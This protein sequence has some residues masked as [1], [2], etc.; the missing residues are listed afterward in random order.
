MKYLSKL[1]AIL[2]ALVMLLSA[3]ATAELDLSGILDTDAL[4]EELV[5]VED[6]AE[7]ENLPDEWWNI[8]LLG[9]DDRDEDGVA[10][11]RTDSMIILSVNLA[12]KEARLTS[13]MRDTWVPIEGH[14][15]N[16]LNSACVKGGPDLTMSTINECFGTNIKH[17]AMVNISGLADVIDRLGGVTLN[18]TEEERQALNKGLFDLS[19]MSGMEKLEKAGNGVLL[20]GNQAVAFA[21]I[22]K[23]DSDYQR[24][25]RQRDVLTAIAD[26]LKENNVVT[27]VGVVNGLLPYVET[28]LEL[29]D[30]MTLA[31]IGLQLD[32][33]TIKQLRL[34][35]DGTYESGTYNGVW[36]IKP[37]FEANQKKLYSFLAS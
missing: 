13:L 37:D 35:A 16:K 2:M 14:G 28:N 27:I 36:C 23:I 11:G 6:Y 18:V 8:L 1:L 19:S 5:S 26:R 33:D 34:P 30:L 25:E 20:N 22:R 12:T 7:T 9:T 10:Y 4:N 29:S 32:I 24:T 3:A 31:Y 17:Y 15:E 21:R